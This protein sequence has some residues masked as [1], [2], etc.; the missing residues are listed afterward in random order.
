MYRDKKIIHN[1]VKLQQCAHGAL[2]ARKTTLLLC[3][4]YINYIR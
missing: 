2:N 1:Y 3:N 4:M